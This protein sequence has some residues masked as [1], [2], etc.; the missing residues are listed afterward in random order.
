MEGG[1]AGNYASVTMAASKKLSRRA[2]ARYIDLLRKD[3]PPRETQTG[4]VA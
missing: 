1:R 2:F 3:P 4:I